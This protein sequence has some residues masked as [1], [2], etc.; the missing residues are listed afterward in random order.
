ME[1]LTLF[2]QLYLF[3]LFSFFLNSGHGYPVG[4][5]AQAT[6]EFIRRG[7]GLLI[8]NSTGRH[9]RPPYFP[10]PLVPRKMADSQDAAKQC[11]NCV[12]HT[13]LSLSLPLCVC[14]KRERC[15]SK[16]RVDFPAPVERTVMACS[17]ETREGR[18]ENGERLIRYVDQICRD[19]LA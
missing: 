17:C 8:C 5:S 6:N 15:T 1:K 11:A 9:R 3:L 4:S 2:L 16:S 14:E 13:C 10:L 7:T 18:R 12:S 19:T